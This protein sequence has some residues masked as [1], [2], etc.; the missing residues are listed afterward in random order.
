MAMNF[1]GNG[2]FL[3][4]SPKVIICLRWWLAYSPGPPFSLGQQGLIPGL[5]GS[6][7]NPDPLHIKIG[8]T[9]RIGEMLALVCSRFVFLFVFWS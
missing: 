4:S 1:Q 7:L 2:S 5:W 8:S 3:L 9:P 6:Y